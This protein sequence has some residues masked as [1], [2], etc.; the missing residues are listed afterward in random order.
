MAPVNV[1]PRTRTSADI[2]RRNRLTTI[3]APSRYRK[4]LDHDGSHLWHKFADAVEH[5]L[6]LPEPAAIMLAYP[7]RAAKGL[8][9]RLPE[10]GD[11]RIPRSV[12]MTPSDLDNGG[13]QPDIDQGRLVVA[14][15]T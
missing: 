12:R 11:Q 14:Y 15:C 9:G 8:P 5:A 10:L 1:R 13:A 3:R 7:G 4:S 6:Q 2:M